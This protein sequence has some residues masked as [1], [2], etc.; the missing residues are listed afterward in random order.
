MSDADRG[1]WVY[2]VRHGQTVLNAQ[3]RFRG[4]ENPPLDQIGHREAQ[5][6]AQELASAT[7]DAVYSSPLAR[8]LETAD[9]IARPHGLAVEAAPGLRDLEYG[10]WSGRT[11]DDVARTDGDL[12]RR[13]RAD[14]ESVTPPAGESVRSVA[15]RALQSIFDVAR[16]HAGGSVVAVTHDVPIR[17]ILG[18]I[19]RLPPGGMWDLDVP[20]G[21]IRRMRVTGTQIR[22]TP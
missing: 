14:P 4:S 2:L 16:R 11:P 19:A 5:R 3:G 6:A 21:S 9:A 10:A 1:C 8:A 20:T 22:L 12:Y 7:L 18:R 15:D 13:F 17:L